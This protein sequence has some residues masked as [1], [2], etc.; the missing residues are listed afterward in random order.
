MRSVLTALEMAR[1]N[2]FGRLGVLLDAQEVVH[3]LKGGF[4]WS[5]YPIILDIRALAFCPIILDIKDLAFYPIILDI[6]AL[7]FLFLSIDF[8]F[9]LRAL[10]GQAHRLAKFCFLIRQDAGWR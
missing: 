1:K 4:D 10:Y 3:A 2:G 5:I 6:K 7:A 9:I 8:E